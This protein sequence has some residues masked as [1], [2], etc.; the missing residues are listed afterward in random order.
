M[1][2]TKRKARDEYALTKNKDGSFRYRK[3]LQEDKEVQQEL[4]RKQFE[5]SI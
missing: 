3:R 5:P 2:K 4:K 1:S